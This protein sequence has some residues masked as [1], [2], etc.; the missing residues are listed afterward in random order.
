MEDEKI[1]ELYWRRRECAIDETQAKYGTYC[2]S[3]AYN[4]LSDAE[5]ALE[6]ENDTYMAAWNAMPPHRPKVLSTFLGKLTRRISLDRWKAGNAQKRGGG[7]ITL[8]LNE[9]TDCIPIGSSLSD[10]LEAQELG[11]SISQFL[12]TLPIRDR[13]IFLRRY[14]YCDSITQIAKLFSCGE[15]KIKMTLLR[16][17]NKLQEHLR[18]EGYIQ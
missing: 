12:R 11:Q 17:R 10:E 8:S 3:I 9:L 5:D 15:S 2:R 14:W 1:V 16:T 7:T 18:K 6:C 4:I 13:Q